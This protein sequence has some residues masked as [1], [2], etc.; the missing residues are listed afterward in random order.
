MQR[1]WCE[2]KKK[3]PKKQKMLKYR[4][5]FLPHQR[6]CATYGFYQRIGSVVC[7]A[8]QRLCSRPH[9]FSARSAFNLITAWHTNEE[10]SLVKHKTAAR[11]LISSISG[12]SLLLQLF[13]L[14]FLCCC[15][16]NDGPSE[17][18]RSLTKAPVPDTEKSLWPAQQW[19]RVGVINAE[20][21]DSSALEEGESSDGVW[22]L[23]YSCV[24]SMTINRAQ[25]GPEAPS[26]L[27]TF[28][29]LN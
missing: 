11:R 26:T 18:T 13:F 2:P 17:L 12:S 16:K 28:L 6:R 25:T 23:K 20:P 7:A 29:P 1:P 24:C 21:A 10:V 14:F 15:W 22:E 9:P 3:N 19:M 5:F 8:K 27:Y 4:L